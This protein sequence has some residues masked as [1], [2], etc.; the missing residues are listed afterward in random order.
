MDLSFFERVDYQQ[1][2]W[3][4]VIIIHLA[5]PF[6]IFY[7][8]KLAITFP[9]QK[10]ELAAVRTSPPTSIWASFW[11]QPYVWAEK[12]TK[13]IR[14]S[15]HF[16]GTASSDFTTVARQTAAS[17]GHILRKKQANP[18]KS[19]AAGAAFCDDKV[20]TLDILYVLPKTDKSHLK[21]GVLGRL[22]IS[23]DL[24]ISPE[25]L[26]VG[27]GDPTRTGS[28]RNRSKRSRFAI[29]WDNKRWLQG[30]YPSKVKP[31]DRPIK[32][33]W[34]CSSSF[35]FTV[36]GHLYQ[37][38]SNVLSNLISRTSNP[39]RFQHPNWRVRAT[40]MRWA[41]HCYTGASVKPRRFSGKN[42]GLQGR[43]PLLFGGTSKFSWRKT[44]QEGKPKKIKKWT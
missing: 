22:F 13:R 40:G 2:I 34:K 27:P 8:T 24:A 31:I 33:A 10:K 39:T 28:G 23:L 36:L 5:L 43:N 7:P 15:F 35:I 20:W 1:I 29:Y 19:G 41:C 3:Q 32:N 4:N 26:T 17:T 12:K 9:N 6:Y 18:C 30:V 16:K 11:T 21:N 25:H 44:N 38:M 14:A 37:K 42:G